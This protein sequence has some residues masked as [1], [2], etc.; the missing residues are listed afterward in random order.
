MVI[1]VEFLDYEVSATRSIHGISSV[2]NQFIA[3]IIKSLSLVFSSFTAERIPLNTDSYSMW[4]V[5]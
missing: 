1:P 2:I 4:E 3:L 5:L